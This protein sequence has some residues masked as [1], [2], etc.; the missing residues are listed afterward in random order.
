MWR[1][2]LR[3]EIL[4]VDKFAGGDILN[5]EKSDMWRNIYGFFVAKAIL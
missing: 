2:A 4:N 5:V 1:K 3:E